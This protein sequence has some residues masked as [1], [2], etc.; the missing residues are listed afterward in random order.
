MRHTRLSVA[1]TVISVTIPLLAGCS[2]ENA[3]SV[4]KVIV[5]GAKRLSSSGQTQLTVRYQ[6]PDT[7][8]YVLVIYPV[9]RSAEDEAVL[10][11]IAPK[12]LAV[13]QAGAVLS[14]KAGGFSNTLAVWRQGALATFSM[15]FRGVAEAPMVLAVSKKKGGP[16]DI[17]LN[18]EGSKVFI[19]ELR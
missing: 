8:P 6:P 16:T 18:R 11:R 17:A 13:S 5:D 15:S 4:S 14:P 9:V 12:A 10:E 7:N 2:A 1:F 19:V 3:D